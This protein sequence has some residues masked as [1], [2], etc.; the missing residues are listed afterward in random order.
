MSTSLGGA[1]GLVRCL[2]AAAEFGGEQN[3]ES[4]GGEDRKYSFHKF[5]LPHFH[6]SSPAS[7]DATVMDSA[8][9]DLSG[10]EGKKSGIAGIPKK[11]LGGKF[12]AIRHRITF[13]ANSATNE[14]DSILSGWNPE[15]RKKSGKPG[16][17]LSCVPLFLIRFFPFLDTHG[18]Q[19][20]TRVRSRHFFLRLSTDVG[21][22]YRITKIEQTYENKT[23]SFSEKSCQGQRRSSRRAKRLEQSATHADQR[24]VGRGGFGRNLCHF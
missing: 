17:F 19:I 15:S 23:F 9:A 18:F 6:S 11:Q 20:T 4:E 14:V 5:S 12:D 3:V 7:H 24:P 21:A 10:I 22:F 1:T 8:V 2:A 16:I 13:T